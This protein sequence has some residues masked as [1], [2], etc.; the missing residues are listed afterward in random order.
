[1]KG[2]LT[3][4]QRRAVCIMANA[5][6]KEGLTLSAAFRKAWR[7]IKNTMTIRA[8]GTTFENRQERLAF[9]KKFRREDLT[10]TLAH[11]PQCAQDPGAVAITIHI[12]PIRKR[13]VI[14]YIPRGLAGEL[15]KLMEGGIQLK[16]SFLEIIGGYSYKENLGLLLNI[17]V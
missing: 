10:V 1:M 3:T 9:L 13:T 12:A 2:G 4:N 5:L 14:G 17:A 16:A 11:D 6:R 8:K 7:R 15:L